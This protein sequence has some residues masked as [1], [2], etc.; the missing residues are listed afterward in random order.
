MEKNEYYWLC[1]TSTIIINSD[2]KEIQRIRMRELNKDIK[3]NLLK[4]NQFIHSSVIIRKLFLD[5]IW[6][7][8]NEKWNWTEDYELWL[9]LW[10]ISKFKN[11]NE[12]LL[13]Y[14]WLETSIS[15]KNQHNQQLN[16]IKL[17]FKNKDYYN[18]FTLSI[19]YRIVFYIATKIFSEKSLKYILWKLKNK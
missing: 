8:Y 11:L 13:K 6:W 2:W 14:R 15:R 3:N 9:R 17:W 1:W 10:K 7:L 12:Y 16:S 18:N 5:Q 4:S 19:L